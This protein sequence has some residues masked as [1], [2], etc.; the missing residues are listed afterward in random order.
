MKC[1]QSQI[2]TIKGVAGY[3]CSFNFNAFLQFDFFRGV[4]LRMGGG[5][6]RKRSHPVTGT[7]PTPDNKQIKRAKWMG[8][9]TVNLVN[10]VNQVCSLTQFYSVGL[11][12]SGVGYKHAIKICDVFDNALGHRRIPRHMLCVHVSLKVKNYNV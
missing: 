3:K 9:Q 7:G 8:F 12:Q 4:L 6:K 11:S 1:A 10:M 5:N 2:Y